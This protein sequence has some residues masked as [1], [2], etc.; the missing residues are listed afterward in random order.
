MKRRLAVALVLALMP[1]VA[2]APAASASEDA[3]CDAD[4]LVVIRTPKGNT[5]AVFNTNGVKGL[6]HQAALLLA[7]VDYTV[8]SI[9]GGKKTLVKMQVTLPNGLHGSGFETRAKIST[10]PMGTLDVLAAG[11]AVTGKPI[12]LEFVL[13]VA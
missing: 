3:W 11:D 12:K 10:G 4:P 5:V 2:L 9:D 7:D 1:M 8:Q 6:K 13:D